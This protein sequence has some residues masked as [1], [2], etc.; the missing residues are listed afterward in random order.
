MHMNLRT[1]DLTDTFIPRSFVFKII[2]VPRTYIM[3]AS[4]LI[5]G[6]ANNTNAKSCKGKSDSSL[7]RFRVKGAKAK[8]K[9]ASSRKDEPSV[10]SPCEASTTVLFH[11]FRPMKPVVAKPVVK[12]D[13]DSDDEDDEFEIIATAEDVVVAPAGDGVEAWE[14]MS[15][16]D[17]AVDKSS[18]DYD[19]ADSEGE[20]GSDHSTPSSLGEPSSFAR[21]ARRKMTC[22][23]PVYTGPQLCA[24]EEDF[25]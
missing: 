16:D 23:K 7:A 19:Y 15:D 14:A 20:A 2:L 25:D 17:D 8:A 24:E 5:S 18:V 9:G 13:T 10:P 4:F 3:L 1:A 21:A 11:E 6:P 12:H 22:S